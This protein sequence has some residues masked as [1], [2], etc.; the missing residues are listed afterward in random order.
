MRLTS[1]TD[2]S[3]RVLMHVAK[4]NGALSSIREVSEEYDISKNH[5]MKI[6]HALGKGGYLETIRGKNGGFK[7]GQDAK[8]INIGKLIRYT[9]EDMNIVQ[10]LGD[11]DGNCSLHKK[12]HFAC[13]INEA[14]NAFL[15]AVDKYTLADIVNDR[16]PVKLS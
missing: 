13:V 4:K 9:E 8:K 6:V 14:R 1:F 10:C 2:Y 7:L 12:C 11:Q 3:V 16:P 15:A 5:L